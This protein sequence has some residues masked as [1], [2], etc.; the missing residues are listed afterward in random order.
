MN[1]GG[2][3][4][5]EVIF[6]DEASLLREV[7]VP[8]YSR[9]KGVDLGPAPASLEVFKSQPLPSLPD[10]PENKAR[11]ETRYDHLRQY[12]TY[13]DGYRDWLAGSHRSR[14]IGKDEIRQ[15]VAQ[16]DEGGQPLRG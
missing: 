2:P 15:F 13:L 3:V 8:Y 4:K 12:R 11:D 9:G 5:G 16:V 1:R 14:Q 6:H 7:I 10:S